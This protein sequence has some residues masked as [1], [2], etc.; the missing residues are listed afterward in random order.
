MPRSAIFL[1]LLMLCPGS[2]LGCSQAPA[3]DPPPPDPPPPPAAEE[4]CETQT[5]LACIDSV[6][7]TLELAEDDSREYRCRDA[8]EPCE[9]GFRQ[10]GGDAEA[11]EAKPGCRFVPGRCYCSPDVTCI[12][13]G[14][15]PAQC[16]EEEEG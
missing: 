7:C 5:E 11:C 15:P 14:G 10:S 16:A 12:C 2:L 1:I 3:P 9:T 13:G 8:E 4:P 6:R